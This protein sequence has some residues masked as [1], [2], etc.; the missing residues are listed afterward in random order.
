ML[1]DL[2]LL[3]LILL[4]VFLILCFVDALC[5]VRLSREH[6]QAGDLDQWADTREGILSDKFLGSLYVY[7]ATH[8]FGHSINDE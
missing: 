5:A 2:L 4:L 3:A 8:L 6:E 1:T 7:V